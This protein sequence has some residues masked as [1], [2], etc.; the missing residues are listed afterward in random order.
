VE[1]LIYPFQECRTVIESL[2]Q[3]LVEIKNELDGLPEAKEPPS[4][5][6]QII[7]NNQQEQD[8]QRLLFHYLSPEE[9]HG[10]DHALLEHILS[11]LADRK[12]LGFSFSR[13]DLTEVEIKQE[14]TIPNGRRP[15]AVIWASEDWFICW[16]LKINA[17]E[18]EDQTQDYVDA[19]SFQSIGL[20]KEDVPAANHHY[21][22]LAP[23]DSYSTD[24]DKAPPEASEFIPV[25][26]E[27]IAD[28]IQTF[29]AESHGAYPGRTIAQLETFT[30]TIQSELQMTEYE[31]NQQEKVELFVEHYDE[32]S[33]VQ[34]AFGEEWD[35]FRKTWGT[36]LAEVL[37]GTVIDN[38]PDVPD[39][40]A[41]VRLTMDG[42]IHEEWIFGQDSDWAA[43]YPTESWLMKLDEREPMYDPSFRG[44]NARVYFLHR[45]GDRHKSVAIGDR[46]LKFWLQNGG[47][48][49]DDFYDNFTPRFHS[50][51]QISDLIPSRTTRTGNKSNV[52]E[53]TYNIDVDSH[54]DFFEA[55]I[56]ALAR[57]VDEHVISNPELV[58]RI[59]TI[60]QQ[61]IEEDTEF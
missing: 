25:S 11:A 28:E 7:R 17:S 43:L 23:E 4:T 12:D 32:I 38:H 55:Y 18:G 41:T 34:Q 42:D 61:T 56:A 59:T 45:I 29:L 46:K 39:E 35:E 58:D 20:L 48:S 36:R 53:A 9:A 30:G 54:S 57:A 60:Y 5:A 27:W 31:E 50:D 26:W 52:L 24:S 37:D 3:K 6:L 13:F 14:V 8:W 15:D 22:Y 1:K 33:E 16:E 51:G 10:L 40:K 49:S 2:R 47:F 19:S 21:V 44:P